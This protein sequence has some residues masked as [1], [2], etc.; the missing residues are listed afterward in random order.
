MSGL[1]VGEPVQGHSDLKA[2]DLWKKSVM[3]AEQ[4]L[5]PSPTHPSSNTSLSQ[6]VR[7]LWKDMRT[8]ILMMVLIKGYWLLSI[9]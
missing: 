2:I 5:H 6:A 3:S 9:T 4:L 7:K 8:K 1:N